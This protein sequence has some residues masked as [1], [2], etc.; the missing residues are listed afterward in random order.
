MPALVLIRKFSGFLSQVKHNASL[1]TNMSVIR[2]QPTT[3][4]RY[5]KNIKGCSFSLI[6][7]MERGKKV[8]L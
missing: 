6:L 3:L 1:F 2:Y 8:L 4:Q 7:F 5:A